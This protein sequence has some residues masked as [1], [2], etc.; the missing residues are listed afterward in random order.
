[1]VIVHRKPVSEPFKDDSV[2]W[3]GS[4]YASSSGPPPVNAGFPRTFSLRLP[5]LRLSF[6]LHYYQ[7]MM[8]FFAPLRPNILLE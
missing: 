1:M 2:Y 5:L 4:G 7:M 6:L 8:A 3:P